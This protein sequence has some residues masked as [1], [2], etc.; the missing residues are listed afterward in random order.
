M[1]VMNREE[2][3]RQGLITKIKEN[4]ADIDS[5]GISEDCDIIVNFLDGTKVVF[6][7]SDICKI[8]VEVKK[9]DESIA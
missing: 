2:L 3:I 6:S 7:L 9:H 1:K 4:E 8:A 5:I